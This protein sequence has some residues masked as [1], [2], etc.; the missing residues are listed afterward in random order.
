MKRRARQRVDWDEELRKTE[1]IRRKGFFISALGF[2]V[3]AA[4]TFGAGRLSPGGVEISRKI[5][6]TF[7]LMI[8]A[9]L[10]R[11]IFKRRERLR[12]EREDRENQKFEQDL[13]QWRQEKNIDK[14]PM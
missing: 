14:W 7:C 5:L 6:F 1:R 12:Q 8:A 2:A 9:F 11:L 4:F 13:R 10:V 3:A